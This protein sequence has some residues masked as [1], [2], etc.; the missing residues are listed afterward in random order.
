MLPRRLYRGAICRTGLGVKMKRIAASV[1]VGVFLI[2]TVVVGTAVAHTVVSDTS[3][4]IHKAPQGITN[5]GGE[6]FAVRHIAHSIKRF[7]A[8]MISSPPRTTP[9]VRPC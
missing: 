8:I 1:I 2:T 3:L 5:A 9:S 6:G 4:T 7:V